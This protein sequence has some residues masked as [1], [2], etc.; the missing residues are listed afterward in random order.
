[1]HVRQLDAVAARFLHE[2]SDLTPVLDPSV[3][4]PSPG[5]PSRISSFVSLEARMITIGIDP[6]KSTT[7]TAVGLSPDGTIL[8]SVRLSVNTGTSGELLAFADRWPQRQWAVE[9]DS[10]LGL[11]NAQQ[12]LA[13][14]QDVLDVPATL[15]AR[16]RLLS[17]GHG[18]KTD[19]NDAATVAL[20]HH[21]RRLR[22]VRAADLASVIRLVSDHRDDLGG[23]THQRNEPTSADAARSHSRRRQDATV[24][25][26]GRSAI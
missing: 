7:L 10:G 11:G 4:A 5:C 23:R 17:P 1:M 21:H 3:V 24:H 22:H 16:T 19:A 18:G 2:L 14:G 15:T 25:P 8:A 26:S 13:R 20:A 9:G 6:H 12:L